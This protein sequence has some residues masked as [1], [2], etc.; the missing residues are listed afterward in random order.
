[1]PKQAALCAGVVVV[2]QLEASLNMS[3]ETCWLAPERT[4]LTGHSHG[5]PPLPTS[6]ASLA[7]L[8]SIHPADLPV[9]AGLLFAAAA[10]KVTAAKAQK[11]VVLCASP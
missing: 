2:V 6:N 3:K 5:V 4:A 8:H 1:M 10:C 7:L 11:Q 9:L